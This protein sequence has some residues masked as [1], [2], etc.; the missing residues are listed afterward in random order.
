MV[1][2]TACIACQS[3]SRERKTKSDTEI[4]KFYLGK[5]RDENGMNRP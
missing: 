1:A 4:A 5:N 3:R 2:G